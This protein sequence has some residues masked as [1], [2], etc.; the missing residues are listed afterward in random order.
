[1]RTK[2]FSFPVSVEW[3]GDSRVASRVDGKSEI[4]TSSPPEF[5]GTDATVWSPQ[6]FFV[7]ATASC[8]AITLQGIAG[9]RDLPIHSLEV[10]CDGTVGRREDERFGFSRMTGLVE[11]ETEPGYEEQARQIAHEAKEKC[12]VAVSLD[13]PIEITV[14]VRVSPAPA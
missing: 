1:M 10:S 8:L 6:D 2:E 14:E 9:R 3:L 4:V 11:I 12:L 5:R 7:A 13:L